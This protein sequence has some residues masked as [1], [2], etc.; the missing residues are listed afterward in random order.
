M[1]LMGLFFR[2]SWALFLT[3]G[4]IE[5]IDGWIGALAF[6]ELLVFRVLLGFAGF[7]VRTG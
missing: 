6:L 7:I 1:E 5:R 4:K 3:E 2:S